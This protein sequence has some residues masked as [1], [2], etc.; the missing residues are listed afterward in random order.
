MMT[1]GRP[2]SG[3]ACRLLSAAGTELVALTRLSDAGR[4]AQRPGS[5]LVEARAAV[6]G[7]IVPW[8]EWHDGLTPAGPAHRGME[9]SWALSGARA[10]GDRPTWGAPLGVV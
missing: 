2:V 10:L 3:P 9:L 5:N 6:D 4:R 7:S 8:R 1:R